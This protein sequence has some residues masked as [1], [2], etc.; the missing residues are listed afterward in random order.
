MTLTSTEHP[1][2]IWKTTGALGVAALALTACAGDD[3]SGELPDAEQDQSN[4]DGEDA[5]DTGTEDTDPYGAEQQGDT[6]GEIAG[7]DTEDGEGPDED[8]TD[9]PEFSEIEEDIWESST[10]QDSVTIEMEMTGDALEQG[11]DAI[12]Q[13]LSEAESEFASDGIRV[14]L[15]GD[16]G[17]DGYSH[18][19]EGLGEYLGF[20]DTIYQSVD[21]IVQEY[22][23]QMPEGSD[24]PS[25]EELREALEA[26]GEW[27]DISS[28]ASQLE[29][30][31]DFINNFREGFAEGSGGTEISEVPFE[32]AVDT[33]DGENVWVYTAE[34]NGSSLEI[35]V[36]ADEGEPLLQQIIIL[37]ENEDE[38]RVDFSEYNEAEEPE[39]PEDDVVIPEEELDAI[40]GGLR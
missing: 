24:A 32:G 14:T 35:V 34:T 22:E 4:G 38:T 20:G 23:A 36:L 7:E 37:D 25:G 3:Q 17:G 19:T 2:W 6:P 16:M 11:A 12:G 9:V 30:P 1:N 21:S 28:L 31:E 10:D 15:S 8:T 26:E 18:T 13:E 33:V 29:T 5:P 27:A 39:E 40:I